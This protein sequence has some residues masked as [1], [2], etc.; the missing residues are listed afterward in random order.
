MFLQDN[1]NVCTAANETQKHHLGHVSGTRTDARGKT[2]FFIFIFRQMNI[3]FVNAISKYDN[4]MQGSKSTCIVGSLVS[5]YGPCSSQV[6]LRSW[7][8]VHKSLVK[9]YP[10]LQHIYTRDKNTLFTQYVQ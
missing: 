10:S 5:S 7:K 4:K 6:S 2:K 3:K 8:W 1:Q 9:S